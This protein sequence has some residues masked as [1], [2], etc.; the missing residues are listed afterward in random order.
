V[1]R[2]GLIIE[3]VREI[4]NLGITFFVLHPQQ[5]LKI[6][7]WFAESEKNYKPGDLLLHSEGWPTG[8]IRYVAAEVAGE[9]TAERLAPNLPSRAAPGDLPSAAPFATTPHPIGTFGGGGPE[10]VS[11]AARRIE[12]T[13]GRV[14]PP[15]PSSMAGA[16]SNDARPIITPLRRL[17]TLLLTYL[18]PAATGAL[19]IV[20]LGHVLPLLLAFPL[21]A[22]TAVAAHAVLFPVLRRLDSK[23]S[24]TAESI[25]ESLKDLLFAGPLVLGLLFQ[26]LPGT[27]SDEMGAFTWPLFVLSSWVLGGC[28]AWLQAWLRL[29]ARTAFTVR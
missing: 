6:F 11:E 24:L 4:P 17:A 13:Q 21:W 19:V 22:V 12:P 8:E 20:G 14:A 7:E 5:V 18:V 29:R 10:R 25:L 9:A 23:R 27:L 28:A 26:W 2:R 1:A 3:V 16:R 15:V